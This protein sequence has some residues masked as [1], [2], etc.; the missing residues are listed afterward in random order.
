MDTN[1]SLTYRKGREFISPHIASQALTLKKQNEKK[2]L[3][4]DVIGKVRVRV[5]V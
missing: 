2:L 4:G 5:V 1:K 3:L